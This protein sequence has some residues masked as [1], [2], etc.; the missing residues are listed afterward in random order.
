MHR[1]L[2]IPEL[3]DL[4]FTSLDK[5]S[6][7]NNALVCRSWFNA[8]IDATWRVVDHVDIP[9][10]LNILTPLDGLENGKGRNVKFSRNPSAKDW[11]RFDT[12]RRRVRVLSFETYHFQ[13]GINLHT[14]VFDAIARTRI[15]FDIFPNLQS[16]SVDAKQRYATLFMHADIKTLSV[17]LTHETRRDQNQPLTNNHTILHDI[18]DRM[19]NLTSL[20]FNVDTID[21]DSMGNGYFQTSSVQRDEE[22]ICTLLQSLTSLRKLAIPAF[23]FT[24]TIAE[25]AATLPYLENVEAHVDQLHEAGNPLDIVHWHPFLLQEKVEEDTLKNQGMIDP[26]TTPF[27]PSLKNFV[28]TAR[29]AHVADFI[30]RICKLTPTFGNGFVKLVVASPRMETPDSLQHL[31][32]V[33]SENLR[34]IRVLSLTSMVSAS[35]MPNAPRTDFPSPPEGD[36]GSVRWTPRTLLPFRITLSDIRPL[37][38]LVGLKDLVIQHHLPLALSVSDLE[39]IGRALPNVERLVLGSE[40]C[41]ITRDPNSNSWG[42]FIES[43][44]SLPDGGESSY[45]LGLRET[46]RAVGKSFPKIRHLGIFIRVSTSQELDL[47]EDWNSPEDR[48]ALALQQNPNSPTPSSS[49]SSACLSPYFQNLKSLDFGSSAIVGNGGDVALILSEYV[50][51]GVTLG[52]GVGWG[53]DERSRYPGAAPANNPGGGGGGVN[54]A[55]GVVMNAAGIPIAVQDDDDDEDVDMGDG[56]DD[57]EEDPGPT[58]WMTDSFGLPIAEDVCLE[59][60]EEGECLLTGLEPLTRHLKS[61]ATA[62]SDSSGSILPGARNSQVFMTHRRLLNE[63]VPGVGV[64]GFKDH[65]TESELSSR[66]GLWQKVKEVL[67]AVIRMRR[68]ERKRAKKRWEVEKERRRVRGMDTGMQVDVDVRQ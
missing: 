25:V 12:Y 57:D 27:F 65:G 11:E 42:N 28:I 24:T 30:T 14:S 54:P 5:K 68:Q 17:R 67:P 56:F 21:F 23:W 32:E 1:V 39:T 58:A 31:V 34:Q 2:E 13:H 48:D 20:T 50:P 36:D 35:H 55:A 47:L 26:I 44:K 33:I 60:D 16:Y 38:N 53:G 59:V 4:I 49:S 63:Y 66:E 6:N 7:L 18:A 15:S 43:K 3:L 40:P 8:A 22:A 61:T 29:Y 62:N 52:Y 41:P 45:I 37:L 9:R 51:L 64:R 10:L 19:P 46:L